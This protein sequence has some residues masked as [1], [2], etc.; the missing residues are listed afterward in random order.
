MR[1]RFLSQ[2]IA[3]KE[4][5]KKMPSTT[6][7]ATSRSAKRPEF[8]IHFNA[9]LAFFWTHGTVSIALK[10]CCRCALSLMYVSEKG[11]EAGV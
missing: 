1:P 9:Q 8:E 6:A 2:K 4:P 3:Q 5:E 10:R 7:K 11:R